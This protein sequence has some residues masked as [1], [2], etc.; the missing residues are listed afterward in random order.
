MEKDK[1]PNL[2][3]PASRAGSPSSCRKSVMEPWMHDPVRRN[4]LELL[5]GL[6]QTTAHEVRN[7]LATLRGFLQLEQSLG[8]ERGQPFDH[9]R[10]RALMIAEIDRIDRLVHEYIQLAYDPSGCAVAE[11]SAERSVADIVPLAV[12]RARSRDVAI[13]I[14]GHTDSRFLANESLVKQLLLN[15]LQQ[16]VDTAPSG[17]GVTV[18]FPLAEAAVD[19]S[20]CP[21]SVT[22]VPVTDERLERIAGACGARVSVNM[23]RNEA[24]GAGALRFHVE[25]VVTPGA[26]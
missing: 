6:A 15:V 11:L 8:P 1:Q 13:E 14:A 5:V 9:E 19:I 16:A 20:V 18:S 17:G 25:F 12:A 7:P 24:G 23:T 26:R 2:P 4:R 10:Y 3:L 22:P 21:A